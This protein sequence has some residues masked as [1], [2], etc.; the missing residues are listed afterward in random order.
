M[1]F[2][3]DDIFFRMAGF[4]IPPFDM[5]WLMETIGDY[6][7][8]LQAEETRKSVLRSMKENRLLYELKEITKEEYEK[9]S[10]ELGQKFKDIERADYVNVKQRVNI[11]DHK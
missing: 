11:L 8:Q 1:V 4:S 3:I 7:K 6:A 2:F 10:E 5:L 9:T